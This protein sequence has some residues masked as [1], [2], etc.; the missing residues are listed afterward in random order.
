[1]YKKWTL[2]GGIEFINSFNQSR[3]N[4]TNIIKIARH[5]ANRRQFNPYLGVV[6][7]LNRINS[8]QIYFINQQNKSQELNTVNRRQASKTNNLQFT[9][10]SNSSPETMRPINRIY[11]PVHVQKAQSPKH[12]QH[13]HAVPTH[14]TSLHQ[15]LIGYRLPG[16]SRSSLTNSAAIVG[17]GPERPRRVSN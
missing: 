17:L 1:M 11:R 4:A 3:K 16:D 8:I 15:E 7:K 2:G 5:L 13:F 14:Y 6:K 10:S 12:K 9:V